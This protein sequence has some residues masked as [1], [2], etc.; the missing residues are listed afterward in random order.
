MTPA[1]VTGPATDNAAGT[2]LIERELH[3]RVH[4][5][6]LVGPAIDEV[7]DWL[8]AVRHAWSSSLDRLDEVLAARSTDPE[9]G[10]P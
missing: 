6:A 8:S 4:R 10:T 2:G 7:T 9:E 1:V 5:V 3:G